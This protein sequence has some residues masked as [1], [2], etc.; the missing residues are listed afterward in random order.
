M[1]FVL[2]YDMMV[3]V[4]YTALIMLLFHAGMEMEMCTSHRFVR[5]AADVCRLTFVLHI[6]EVVS[7]IVTRMT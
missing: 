1:K 7:I 5:V 2:L 3:S 6:V 4:I